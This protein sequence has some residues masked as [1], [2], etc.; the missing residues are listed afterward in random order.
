M[1]KKIINWLEKIENECRKKLP[2]TYQAGKSTGGKQKKHCQV[3]MTREPKF[4]R[5]NIWLELRITQFDL[6]CFHNTS[7]QRRRHGLKDRNVA[8]PSM[9]LLLLPGKRLWALLR[10]EFGRTLL[11]TFSKRWRTYH[12]NNQRLH[13]CLLF[14]S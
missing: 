11:R 7:C 10:V 2:R 6:E 13:R 8:K 5:K 14:T 12:K 3:V 4:S 9:M 1:E